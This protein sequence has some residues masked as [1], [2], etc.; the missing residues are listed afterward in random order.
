MPTLRPCVSP[1]C[2]VL[3]AGFAAALATPALAQDSV[4]NGSGD[5]R[6][7][8]FSTGSQTA[9]YVVDLSRVFGSAPGSR[10]GL[11]VL[12]KTSASGATLGAHG[13]SP[14]QILGSTQG[15]SSY[16]RWFQ[17]GQGVHPTSNAAGTLITGPAT[18]NR[19]A[20]VLGEAGGTYSA[21]IAASVLRN[22]AEHTRLFVTR[23][24]LASGSD[25]GSASAWIVA[26]SIDADANAYL[27]ADGFNATAP[28]AL[29]GDGIYRVSASSRSASLNRISTGGSLDLAATDDLFGGP[30]PTLLVPP[31]SIPASIAGGTGLYSGLAF[32]RDRFAGDAGSV[33]ADTG[34]LASSIAA[35]RGSAT[36]APFA[37]SG[38]G[39]AATQ[40][41]LVR[42]NPAGVTSALQLWGVDAAGNVTGTSTASAPLGSPVTNPATGES[43]TI[44]IT[45]NGQ[46]IDAGQFGHYLS[47]NAFE[48]GGGQVALGRDPFTG[49]HVAAATVLSQQDDPSDPINGVFAYR[50]DPASPGAG[51][52]S[53]VAQ[54]DTLPGAASPIWG[55]AGNDGIP[56]T[57]D[58]GEGDGLIDRDDQSA[59]Y[60]APIGQLL[61]YFSAFPAA[62]Q[63][64]PSIS[65]PTIDAA[66]DVYFTASVGLN[67][68]GNAVVP[69]EAL[70]RARFDDA[71]QGWLLEAILAEGQ[72]V[73]G[74]NSGTAFRIDE[75]H[76]SID[77]A[78]GGA[79]SPGAVFS[80]SAGSFAFNGSGLSGRGDARGL[81]GLVVSAQLSYDVDADS[82][83]GSAADESYNALLYLGYIARRSDVSTTN[84]NPGDAGYGVPD[85]IVDGADLSYYVEQWLGTTRLADISTTNNNPGD[86]GFGVADGVVDG[87]DLSFFVEQW[88]AQE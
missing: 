8:P 14:D 51:S 24:H 13:M 57:L 40:A 18:A 77:S 43:F 48:G 74:G 11:G 26:G 6:L 4:S 39:G 73:R 42:T 80:Q 69:V 47:L 2:L 76:V 85:E 1:A 28:D 82:T 71:S 32:A 68:P 56:G 22:P 70:L 66:G 84:S 72:T 65:T 30:A 27:L 61:P 7:D 31:S 21:A 64:G 88:L 38:L 67:E 36:T 9:A 20:T 25:G 75:L 37:T 52:W 46:E 17:A 33:A 49:E 58:A 16:S 23:T 19:F 53:L 55:D 29:G 60:D 59:T 54:A 15:A 83:F 44:P 5:D 81:G 41:A 86:P 45:V 10:L 79:A 62:N 63:V 78:E 34:H 35:T 3:A 87:A 50:F 12:A